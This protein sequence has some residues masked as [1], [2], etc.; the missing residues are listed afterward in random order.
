[1]DTIR[2]II[3]GAGYAWKSAKV[4]LTSTDSHYEEK[5]AHI[6]E[7]L[8]H[9]RPDERFFSI[10]EFGP[11]AVKAKPG[12]L[13]TAPGVQPSVPRW[14][15]SKGCLILTAALELSANQVT[16]FYSTAKNTDEIMAN[17]LLER[18]AGASTLYLSWDAHHGI[19]R[20]S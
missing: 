12:R 10:D 2:S 6:S 1:M 9:L 18:Y 11:F 8:G 17:A 4:V 19:C 16:H 7:V 3:R 15:M 20:K 13:L 14:Q 5:I